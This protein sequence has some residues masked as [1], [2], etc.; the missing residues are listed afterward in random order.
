MYNERQFSD[1]L[2]EIRADNG[3][4]QEE[5]AKKLGTSKQVISRYENNQR[6]PK[7]TT[8]ADYAAK[9]GVSLEYLLGHE[10]KDAVY[11]A[12]LLKAGKLDEI[13]ELMGLPAGSIFA[14]PPEESIRVTR[15]LAEMDKHRSQIYARLKFYISVKLPNIDE[16]DYEDI[17]LFIDTLAEKKRRQRIKNE[18]AE[19]DST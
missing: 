14:L 3:W 11:I 13:A 18:P 15:E 7:I 4:T 16:H 10:A 9:L 19:T 5:L 17:T 1:V 8:T 6:V 12:K 2:R